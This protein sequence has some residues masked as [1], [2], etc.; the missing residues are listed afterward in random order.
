L[1]RLI[2][3]S[4]F[5]PELTLRH[6]GKLLD[7]PTYLKA[8]RNTLETSFGVTLFSLLLGYPLAYLM[9][10]VGPRMRAVLIAIV[11]IPFWTSILVRTFAWVVILGRNGLINQAMMQVGLIDRPIALIYNMVGVQVGMV[12]VLLPFMILPIYGVMSRI[13]R[14]LIRAARSLG[15]RP[16]S[17]FL[18]IFLP[19][20]VPGVTAGCALV[21]LMAV[22]FYI[23]PALLGGPGQITIA[24]LIEMMVSDL[25]NWGFGATLAVV[26]LTVVGALF[27]VFSSL[28]GLDRLTGDRTL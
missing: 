7:D 6:Y 21:F 11:L 2:M 15:A 23:T 13:D 12:H 25:L 26:L 28:M 1:S 14:S 20:S 27:V 10:I 3:W 19:L 24:T 16:H 9:V 22:G 17:A 4:L 5:D 18:Q 8:L